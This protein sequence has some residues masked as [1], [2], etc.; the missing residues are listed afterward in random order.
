MKDL[1]G[2]KTEKNLHDA[3]AGESMA[4]NKYSYFASVAKKEG[5]VQISKYFEET[6]NNERAH[7][8]IWFK[9]LK[10]IGDT[11]QN[12]QSCV[13]GEHYEWTDM[14]VGFAETAREE[15]FPEIA[16]LFEGVAAIEKHHEER[17]QR[18]LDNVKDGAVFKKDGKKQWIC[19]VCG[20]VHEGEEAPKACIVCGHPQAHFELWCT[21]NY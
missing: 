9:L 6:A 15:G 20:H 1:Q 8:K 4:R 5:F 7:A 14:Y 13:D 10:G 3:F 17:Y 18:L 21:S 2:T 16:K 11:A 19:N 12:L